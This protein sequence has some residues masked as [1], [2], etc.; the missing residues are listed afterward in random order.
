[1]AFVRMAGS[2]YKKKYYL[3]YNSITARGNYQ[4]LPAFKDTLSYPMTK[5]ETKTR[6]GQQLAMD[7]MTKGPDPLD[8][9][10]DEDEYFWG[11]NMTVAIEKIKTKKSYKKINQKTNRKKTVTIKR[12]NKDNSADDKDQGADTSTSIDLTPPPLKKAKKIMNK[13]TKM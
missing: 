1:M 9:K 3:V 11:G 8:K 12:K 10:Y 4:V 7:K 5:W 2:I 13:K 6:A